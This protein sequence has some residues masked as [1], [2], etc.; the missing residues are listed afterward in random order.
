MKDIFSFWNIKKLHGAKSGEYMANSHEAQVAVFW[1][2]A[3]RRD[4]M[5]H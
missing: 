2:V 5:V 4:V 1:T 3:P